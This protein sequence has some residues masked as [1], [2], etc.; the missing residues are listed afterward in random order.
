MSEHRIQNEIRNDLAG[1]LLLWRANVGTGWAGVKAGLKPGQWIQVE[2]GDVLLKNARPLSTGLPPG[3]TDLFGAKPVTITQEMIGTV[4][5]QFAVV[6]VK[7][8]KGRLSA[9]Q[10]KFLAAVKRIGGLAGVARNVEE[11]RAIL[12]PTR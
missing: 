1:L 4:I 3:F 11:A 8:A 7:D 10:E 12:K 2:H 5:A 9:L 6:E